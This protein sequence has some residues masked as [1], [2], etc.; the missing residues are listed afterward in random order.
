M[1]TSAFF[2]LS[3]SKKEEILK[4]AKEEFANNLYE[5]ASINKIIKSIDKPRGTI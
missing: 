3:T 1:P 4:A 2:N 5:D